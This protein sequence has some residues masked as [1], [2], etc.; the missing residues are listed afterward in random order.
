MCII[1]IIDNNLKKSL[2]HPAKLRVRHHENGAAE[3]QCVVLALTFRFY[4]VSVPS[5]FG[6]SDL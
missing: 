2:T 1:H 3:I 6:V 4:V 5:H